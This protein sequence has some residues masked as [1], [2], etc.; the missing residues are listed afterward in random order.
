MIAA[1]DVR[2]LIG[3]PGSSRHHA[4]GDPLVGLGTELARVREDVPVRGD[5]AC[6]WLRPPTPRAP[7]LRPTN[8]AASTRWS[9]NAAASR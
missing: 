8:C 4:V 7:R 6:C 3:Q 9:R 5:A 2:D 1:V